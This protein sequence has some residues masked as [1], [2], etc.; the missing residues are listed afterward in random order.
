MRRHIRCLIAFAL[1]LTIAFPAGVCA[2]S[3]YDAVTLNV[4]DYKQF[5]GDWASLMV[6][7]S[8]KTMKQIGCAI[9][10]LAMAESYRTGKA[11]TP[12]VMK[13][14]LTFNGTGALYWPGNYVIPSAIS[15][16]QLY[17]KLKNNIPVIVGARSASGK[18]HFI[19]VKGY[20]GGQ[21]LSASGF[22][23]ND[24]GSSS[25]TRLSQFLSAYP[26]LYRRVHY[27]K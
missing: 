24:P 23:I 8:G 18:T 22:L 25:R 19:V 9:T 11:I 2:D 15:Y 17:D 12:D 13:S 1:L 3:Y 21:T 20:V 14:R 4:P 5:D 27:A 6:G 7:K 10:S 16:R 26:K